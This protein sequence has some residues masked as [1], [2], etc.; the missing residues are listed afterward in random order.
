[1]NLRFEIINP[2]IFDKI[3]KNV[4]F[5]YAR[6]LT[7]TAQKAQEDITEGIRDKF[8][9]RTRWIEKGNKYGIKVTPANKRNLESAVWTRADWLRVHEEGGTKEPTRSKNLTLPTENVKRN[10]RDLIRKNQRPRNLPRSF[11]IKADGGQRLFM[12][13]F[14]KGKRSSTRV[15]YVLKPK[16]KIKKQGT[17]IEA[18][19]KSVTRNRAEITRRSIDNAMRTMR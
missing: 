14:G 17:F 19:Q 7:Q 2:N 8:T 6:G 1:M 12:Q 13:R 15:M 3:A 16:A 9:V 4:E 11:V 5:G 10:K 18:A